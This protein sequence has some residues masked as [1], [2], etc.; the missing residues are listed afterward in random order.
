MRKVNRDIE[1]KETQ[2]THHISLAYL[3]GSVFHVVFVILF[4]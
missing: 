2:R 1:V 3:L 4:L